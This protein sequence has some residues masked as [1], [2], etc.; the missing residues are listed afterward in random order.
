MKIQTWLPPVYFTKRCFY[1]LAGISLL[2]VLSYSITWLFAVA[3]GALFFLFLFILIDALLLFS[4]KVPVTIKRTLSEKFSNGDE[5]KVVLIFH[6]H[7]RFSISV[8]I[9][10]E[11]PTEFQWRNVS[12]KHLIKPGETIQQVYTLTPTARG[13]YQFYAINVFIQSM[14][15]LLERK[16]VQEAATTVR[17]LPS[18]VQ[19]PQ[20]ELLAYNTH[21]A[22]A[23]NRK[24][25]KIGQSL[26]FEQIKNYI[27]G[28]DL[29]SINWKATARKGGELMV[30]N[31]S[32]ER[33][34]QLYC[35]IDKSR[36]MKMPFNGMTLLDYAINAS[37]VLTQVALV[38]QD[39]AGLI[40]FAE[41]IDTIVPAERKSLQMNAILNALYNLQTRFLESD[42]EK[43]H[44]CLQLRLK[45]RALVVL[46]TN[47]ESMSSLERQL[48]Y[49]RSIAKKHLLLVVFFENTGLS[50]LTHK[51]V[52]NTEQLYIKTIAEK[53]ILEKKLM[54]KALQKHGIL[55]ILTAPQQLTIDTVN[56]YLEI[57][58][59]QAI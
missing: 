48:P 12:F 27:S 44:A 53:F 20:Y 25:R 9:I 57:K 16:Q 24:L 58:A 8:N 51:K 31:Y 4:I 33:S 2:L 36:S 22:E 30:N 54:V 42:I 43:L 10:D 32:D 38:K 50:E 17:V 39:K 45:Q 21:I 52:F 55:T 47:F 14:L 26:E 5:N 37:L 59:K 56:K 11:V 3:L 7:Y 41:Q 23:G 6:H 49:L 34:Q 29:R 18:F 35:I 15:G 46:F 40:C 13:E 19:L 28:D 1:L